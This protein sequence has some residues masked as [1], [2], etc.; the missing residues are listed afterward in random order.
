MGFRYCRPSDLVAS[1]ATITAPLGTVSTD[2]NY[3]LTALVDGNPAKPCQFVSGGSP[4][5]ACAILFNFGSP[6]RVDGI[7]VPSH[8]FEAGLDV[9]V[10]GNAADA[11]G[12]PSLDAPLSI[13]AADLDGHSSQPWADLTT[14]AGYTTSGFQY[15]RLYIPSNSV[16]PQIGQVVLVRQW[17]TFARGIRWDVVPAVERRYIPALE[18]AYGVRTCYDMEV[19]QTR[20]TGIVVGDAEDL[21]DVRR[22]LDDAGGPVRPFVV[23]LDDTD[24]AQGG[25]LV[26]CGDTM[27]RH[28]AEWYGRETRP[29]PV[30]FVEVSRGL[31]L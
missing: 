29:F 8:T 4:E 14:L 26:Q 6:Q 9:R 11:W 5:P 20:I 21:L 18:T 3:D 23:I 30:E 27:L 24:P 10:Q 1:L 22:L 13:A 25:L 16:A 17:R 12:G 2:P 31:P 7:A 15:W 28:A 19:K